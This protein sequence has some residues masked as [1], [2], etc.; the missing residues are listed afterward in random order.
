MRSYVFLILFTIFTTCAKGQGNLTKANSTLPTD[1]IGKFYLNLASGFNNPNGFIG[2]GVDASV[3]PKIL[4]GVGAGLS[5]WGRKLNIRG[6]YF[7]KANHLGS[8]FGLSLNNN[9]GLNINKN[10]SASFEITTPSGGRQR[11]Y[12][13]TSAA[14]SIN[15]M[16]GR[17]WQLGK[18]SKFFINTGVVG[19][20]KAIS[21]NLFDYNTNAPITN[22]ETLRSIKIVSPGGLCF[23]SGFL[24]SLN[25]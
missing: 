18:R 7:L 12:G 21:L 3:S 25:K 4:V 19:K 16:Y 8:A 13:T 23:A 6:M 9:S 5:T 2:L 15:M 10:S 17:Y 24:V 1:K 14:T 20:L 22:T 11:I